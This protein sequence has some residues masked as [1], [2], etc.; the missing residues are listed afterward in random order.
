VKHLLALALLCACSSKAPPPVE[1]PVEPAPAPAPAPVP[2]PAPT[3]PVTRGNVISPPFKAAD[4]KA[5]MPV[6]T[7]LRY[8]ITTTGKPPVI[9]HWRVTAADDKGC[10]IHTIVYANDGTTQIED[11]GPSTAAWADLEKHGEFPATYTSTREATIVVA[12][13]RFDTWFF[14][15]RPSEKG[16]PT[17]RM[18]F[19]RTIAGPPVWMEVSNE[20]VVALKLELVSRK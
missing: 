17:R 16:Q 20:G 5:A 12:A 13:G 8:R 3:G 10:T 6:G 4:L 15:I 7:E 18:H 11:K 9:E 1:K 14:E 2:E 19:A